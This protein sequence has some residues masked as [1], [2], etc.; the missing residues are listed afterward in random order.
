M[1][2]SQKIQLLALIC[3]PMFGLTETGA[4]LLLLAP[5]LLLVQCVLAGGGDKWIPHRMLNLLVFMC[6]FLSLKLAP[7]TTVA[8]ARL[9]STTESAS[10]VFNWRRRSRPCCGTVVSINLSSAWSWLMPT[11]LRKVAKVASGILETL[12]SCS[13]KSS[14]TTPLLEQRALRKRK[15]R[16]DMNFGRPT[17]T[18]ADSLPSC[19]H[20]ISPTPTKRFK[21]KSPTHR[22]QGRCM[23]CGA[24]TIYVC[25]EC[26]GPHSKASDKQHWICCKSDKECMG[27]HILTVH[28]EKSSKKR[29]SRI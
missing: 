2:S 23:V 11:I 4:I 7:P 17:N 8:V 27:K 15:E 20:M 5:R 12:S 19:Y 22:V 21:K 6:W 14:L 24:H 25:R 28:P 29:S 9:I 16:D 26:Q 13:L 1:A 3:S 10:R 18:A